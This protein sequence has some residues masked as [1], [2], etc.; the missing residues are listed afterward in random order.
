MF[1]LGLSMLSATSNAIRCIKLAEAC[2]L[3][4]RPL[5]DLLFCSLP[6]LRK[7]KDGT[8]YVGASAFFPLKPP[9]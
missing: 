8:P 4:F 7:A 5:D 3:T 9:C 1:L 2:D 6:K